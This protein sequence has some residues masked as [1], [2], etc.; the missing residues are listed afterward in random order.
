MEKQP[1]TRILQ[2][3]A[4]QGVPATVDLWPAIRTRLQ[5]QRRI[6][7]RARWM[8]ATRLGWAGLI[9][10][11]LLLFGSVAYALNPALSQVFRAFFPGWQHIEESRLAQELNLSQTQDGVTV[12]LER[13]YADANEI[14]IGYTVKGLADQRM[15]VSQARLSDKQGTV[16]PEL[17]GA[18]VIGDSD[19]LGVQLP[20]GEGAYVTAF[21][22]SAVKGTPASLQL[23]LTM[24]LARLVPVDQAL[25][26]TPPVPQ[27]SDSAA[28]VEP[29]MTMREEIVGGPFT[30]DFSVPFIPGQ[31]VEVQQEVEA[32]GVIMK[33]ERVVVTPSETRAILCFEPP[34]DIEWTLLADLDTG[35]GQEVSTSFVSRLSGNGGESCH[36]VSL[37]SL[38]SQ[39]G[40]WT[41]TVTELV[42]TDLSKQPS[43][44]VRLAGPWVF[45]FRVP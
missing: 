39:S 44:D 20:P 27:S 16:F 31:T 23:H 3:I 37:E 6:P 30:F 28:M 42:G 2:E 34:D 5:P 24:Q 40:L 33:L 14:I 7:R 4:E 8:P 10:G 36:R 19:L 43:E 26:H 9:L 35:A 18:G 21:D 25:T 17:A 15:H 32:A 38:T 1:V 29:V 11:A 22:A 13:A 45:R 41:L 12:T